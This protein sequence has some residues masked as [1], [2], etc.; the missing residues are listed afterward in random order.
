MIPRGPWMGTLLQRSVANGHRNGCRRLCLPQLHLPHF[1]P[2]RSRTS[3]SQDSQ[4][5]EIPACRGCVEV[6]TTPG[7]CGGSSSPGCRASPVSFPSREVVEHWSPWGCALSSPWAFTAARSPQHRNPTPPRR[8]P[9]IC[10]KGSMS[11][12]P[13]PRGLSPLRTRQRPSRPLPLTIFPRTPGG[14]AWTEP[15]GAFLGCSQTDGRGAATPFRSAF[16]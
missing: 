8:H 15:T 9:R 4:N 5:R 12:P 1:R 10:A 13:T 11:A 3:L 7:A 14:T 16:P 6:P 2:R